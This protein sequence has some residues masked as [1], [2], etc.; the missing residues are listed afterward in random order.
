MFTRVLGPSAVFGPLEPWHAGQLAA[1]VERG[2]AYLAPWV[3]LAT[4]IVDEDSA[5]AWM[6]DYAQRQA[7]DTGRSY[8]IWLDATLVGGTVFRVFDTAAG[9]CEIGV[10]LE[11][12]AQGRGLVSAAV[13]LM[14]GW[15]LGERG[16]YRVEWRTDPANARSRAVAVRLGMHLDGVLRGA[17]EVAGV[18][19]DTEVWSL[20]AT[21]WPGTAAGTG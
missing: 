21:E 10:W 5:R 1:N 17:Y 4:R 19:R 8:G 2:R 14:V 11:P 15:A 7:Q 13:R 6:V 16:L 20:L 18:R 9:W 12:A 3:P